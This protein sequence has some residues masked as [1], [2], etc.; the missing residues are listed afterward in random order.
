MSEFLDEL[1]WL[2]IDIETT[3]VNP[4]KYEIIEIGAVLF[5]TKNNI[6]DKFSILI[7][8]V[9][10]QDPK[11]KAIH[12]ISDEEVEEHGYT[13]NEAIHKFLSFIPQDVSMVF[14][15]A[16]FD[17]SFLKIAMLRQQVVLPNNFLL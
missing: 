7:K 5:S 10:K 12:N 13:E 2:A 8:P 9:K 6:T 1:Q 15:N 17:V 3:G 14:H 4:W 11:S 16:P